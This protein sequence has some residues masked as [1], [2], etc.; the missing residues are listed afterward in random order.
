MD[1][2]IV[3]RIGFRPVGSPSTILQGLN[4]VTQ[5]CAERAT[6]GTRKETKNILAQNAASQASISGDALNLQNLGP[7]MEMFR[8]MAGTGRSGHRNAAHRVSRGAGRYTFAASSS[9]DPRHD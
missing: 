6:L 3:S 1:G 7:V 5:C 2:S 4:R 8:S 9:P